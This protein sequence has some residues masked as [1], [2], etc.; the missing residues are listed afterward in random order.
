MEFENK[1]LLTMQ[2]I[3][4]MISSIFPNDKADIVC[5][6]LRNYCFID[7][8]GTLFALQKNITYIKTKDI[9]NK[10]ISNI[11]L[12]LEKSFKL[13]SEDDRERITDKYEKTYSKIFQNSHIR[14]YMPQVHTKLIIENVE[15]DKYFDKIHFNN[16]YYD[17]KEGKFKQRVIHQDYVTAYIKYDYKA[18]TK[19]QRDKVL[20]HIRKIYTNDFD[21]KA[22][23]ME[24]AYTLSGRAV[25]DQSTL[26]LLGEA[27]TGKSFI[28]QLTGDTIECYFKE[29]QDDTFAIG[30]TKLDKILKKTIYQ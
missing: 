5:T 22:I 21:M 2:E 18:S 20:C 17:L 12:L 1:D 29:L 24:L 4:I 6:K 23:I 3:K 30:N 26:F 15:F 9:D 27:S 8:Q 28:M 16:G 14:E 11:S 13:L 7:D 25:N 19:Q 10:L